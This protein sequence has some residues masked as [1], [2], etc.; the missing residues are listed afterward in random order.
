ML[1]KVKIALIAALVASTASAALA[2]PT[3]LQ[4]PSNQFGPVLTDEDARSDV[5]EGEI[6][7]RVAGRLVE[8]EHG[9]A[10]GNPLV[11]QLD[12]HPSPE[13]LDEEQSPGKRFRGEKAA[14]C[15]AAQRAL[16]P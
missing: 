9:L 7:D 16:L 15:R 12:S 8:Q 4:I 11:R 10:V 1:T 6:G 13:G 2:R 5:S 14:R 3:H